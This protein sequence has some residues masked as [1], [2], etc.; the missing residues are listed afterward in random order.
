MDSRR[1]G[2]PR[3]GNR[4]GGAGA[5][6]PLTCRLRRCAG[7]APQARRAPCRPQGCRGRRGGHRPS[8]CA[9]RT[10][11][12]RTFAVGSGRVGYRRDHRERTPI[13]A[14]AGA[15][16]DARSSC[17]SLTPTLVVMASCWPQGRSEEHTS[18]LQSLM[19]ISYAVF[20]LKKK[21]QTKKITNHLY[22]KKQ[23][24]NQPKMTKTK[25]KIRT[26]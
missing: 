9:H 21:K 2:D 24:E 4:S 18:E 10:R 16:N 25:N 7:L 26:K 19:R 20:C 1:R 14:R 5:R 11:H 8:P 6:S 15:R 22:K 23:N 13:H 3:S 17:R 12:R